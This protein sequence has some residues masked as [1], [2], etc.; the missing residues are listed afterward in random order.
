MQVT[1]VIKEG[2]RGCGRRKSGACYLVS[3]PGDGILPLFIL[4]DP[5][6]QYPGSH[7]RGAVQIDLDAVLEQLPADEWLVGASQDRFDKQSRDAVE[8]AQWGMSLKEREQIGIG[9]EG[10]KELRMVN[11]KVVGSQLRGLAKLKLGKVQGEIPKAFASIQKGDL[12]ALLACLW[13]L[14]RNCPPT[15]RV[16]AK[17]YIQ[18][19]MYYL[20]AIGDSIAIEGESNG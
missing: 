4:I 16:P 2:R 14:W 11:V 7:F 19:C 10:L 9:L 5:P 6:V 1:T 18:C 8:V 12:Q 13:R 15:Q 17:N 20:N 3:E